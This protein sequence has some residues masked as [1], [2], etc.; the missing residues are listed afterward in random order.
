MLDASFWARAAAVSNEKLDAPDEPSGP[1]V[2]RSLELEG[3]FGA[4]LGV[5][6]DSLP[7]DPE[8]YVRL[9][10]ELGVWE[11]DEPDE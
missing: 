10:P 1:L 5:E 4:G 7:A 11:D 3:D 8:E 2:L 9:D 6:N